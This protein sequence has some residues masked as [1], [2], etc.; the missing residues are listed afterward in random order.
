MLACTYQPTAPKIVSNSATH[1]RRMTRLLSRSG[2]AVAASACRA[3][4][5]AAT[6]LTLTLTLAMALTLTRTRTLPHPLPNSHPNPNQVDCYAQ[7][8]AD[9]GGE[10]LVPGPRNLLDSASACCEACRAHRTRTEA[11][12]GCNVWVWCGDPGGCGASYRHCWLKRQPAPM[13]LPSVGAL[14]GQVRW[15]SGVWA[16]AAAVEA[17]R[18]AA[19]RPSPSVAAG[20]ELA[21]ATPLGAVRLKLNAAGSPKAVS[22]LRGL[23]RAPHRCHG[24]RFYRAEPGARVRVRVRVSLPLTLPLTLTLSLALALALAMALT[25]PSAAALGA[26]LELRPSVR[27]AAGQLPSRRRTRHRRGAAFGAGGGVCDAP[28]DAHHH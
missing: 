4:R 3:A 18:G 2:L 15:M 9:L 13:V 1:R 25:V 20:A 16:D 6:P 7:P 8:H 17:A 27:A 14:G 28:W 10:P 19:R 5:S 24:C 26:Q 11:G 12:R 21:L 22:W 23:A